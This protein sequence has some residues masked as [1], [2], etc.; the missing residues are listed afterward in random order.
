MEYYEQ[1]YT[2]SL[3]LVSNQ[4]AVGYTNDVYNEYFAPAGRNKVSAI[5]DNIQALVGNTRNPTNN[6]FVTRSDYNG[7]CHD[8]MACY[9]DTIT[10]LPDDFKVADNAVQIKVGDFFIHCCDH[11]HGKYRV[12]L[13]KAMSDFSGDVVSQDMSSIADTLVHEYM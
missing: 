6:I 8:A 1:A 9:T 13:A 3:K 10:F 5:F 4:I 2:D 11:S 12:S 7:L